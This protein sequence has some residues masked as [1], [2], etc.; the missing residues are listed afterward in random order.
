MPSATPG[1][2]AALVLARRSLLL[3][4]PERASAVP[5]CFISGL[6]TGFSERDR[7]WAHSTVGRELPLPQLSQVVVWV[8][9]SSI[10]YVSQSPPM[11]PDGRISRIRFEAAAY[12]LRLPKGGN[13]LKSMV[14]IRSLCLTFAQ[15]LASVG[16]TGSASTASDSCSH[17]LAPRAQ[18]SFA[19]EAL[20]SFIATTTSCASPEASRQ[21]RF[22]TRWSVFAAWTIHCWSS[23]P[24]RC[25]LRESFSRCQVPYSGGTA[26][27]SCLFLLLRH[28][29]SP[30]KNRV[31]FPQ[32]PL[33]D[34]K[35]G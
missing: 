30:R 27:C 17:L 5:T 2:G 12:T 23:G 11:I 4:A 22:Q 34:F 29:P 8:P 20:P 26:G 18:R 9:N 13:E 32:N 33:N 35:A 24:S 1:R 6:T 28:R 16:I 10:A 19:P 21:L 15:S 3:A 31:G 7:N 25:Y 14:D